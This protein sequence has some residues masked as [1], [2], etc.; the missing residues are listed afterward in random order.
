[1]F[2]VNL[3]YDFEVMI[4]ENGSTDKTFEKRLKVH[5]AELRFK[6]IQ[7]S[8]NFLMD[9]GITLGLHYAKGDA[10]VIMT[11]NLQDPPDV[12]PQFI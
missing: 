5:R 1:M 12:I 7:L 4:A 10:A 6:I 2:A 9:G 3:N 11:V 8:R